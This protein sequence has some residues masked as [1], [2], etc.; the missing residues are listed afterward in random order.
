MT[1][2]ASKESLKKRN[3]ATFI[4]LC[5]FIALIYSITVVRIQEGI[6]QKNLSEQETIEKVEKPETV[7]E[8]GTSN[9]SSEAAPV[10][11]EGDPAE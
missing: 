5:A 8:I 2:S 9:T 4:A 10:D 7:V 3:F 1:K 6:Y 11:E